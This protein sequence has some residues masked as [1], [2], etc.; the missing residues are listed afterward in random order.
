MNFSCRLFV[1]YA[2]KRNA[3]RGIVGLLSQSGF[4]EPLAEFR[5]VGAARARSGA[6]IAMLEMIR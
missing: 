5:I 6:V 1:I 2:R 4:A 3:L